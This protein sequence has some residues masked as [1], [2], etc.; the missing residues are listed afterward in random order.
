MLPRTG[1]P[2]TTARV[3]DAGVTITATATGTPIRYLPAGVSAGRFSNC[4][5]E[6]DGAVKCWGEIPQI[7]TGGSGNVSTPTA[8]SGGLAASLLAGGST[9]YCALDAQ[10][11]IWCWGNNALVDTSGAT[12]DATV[13]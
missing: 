11:A 7:G 4:A 3:A 13:S 10:N 8:V 12:V 9:H 2:P 6:M 1:S 5:I